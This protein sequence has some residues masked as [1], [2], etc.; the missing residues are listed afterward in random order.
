MHLKK[1]LVLRKS[2]ILKSAE[3]TN[4]AA[5]LVS[6]SNAH[7]SCS[8]LAL[9]VNDSEYSKSAGA[10]PVFKSLLAVFISFPWRALRPY[11]TPPPFFGVGK[12]PKRKIA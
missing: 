9:L 2:R 5:R 11:P 6:A 10:K 12:V 8:F 1:M 3:V 7:L 4:P